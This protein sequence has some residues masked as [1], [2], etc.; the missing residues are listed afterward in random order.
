MRAKSG[1]TSITRRQVLKSGAAAFTATAAIGIAPR[2]LVPSVARAA[3]YASGMTGG[4]TGF[5]GAERYQYNESMS[6]GRAIEG[7]KQLKAAGKAPDKLVMMIL[8]GALAHLNKPWPADAPTVQSVWEKESGITLEFVTV[9]TGEEFSKIIRDVTTGEG[10][11]D[12]YTMP[13]N[14]IGDLAEAGGLVNCDDFVAKYQPDF[15]DAERGYVGG[16]RGVAQLNQ[17]D[18]VNYAV[19]LDG[20][21]QTWI[22][23]KDLFESDAERNKFSA[24]FGRELD[25]PKTFEELDQVSQ[26]FHRPDQG[27]NGCTDLRNQGW[28]YTNWY[29]RYASLGVPNQYL[30]S[31]DGEPLIDGEAGIQAAREY[32]DSLKWHST[33]AVSWSWP[34]QYGSM[35]DGGTAITC[36]FPNMPKFVDNDQT[37]VHNKMASALPPGRLHGDKLV[38]RSVLWYSAVGGVSSLSKYPEATWLFL[39]W[40][41][42]TRIFTWMTG[43]PGGYYDPFQLANFNDPLVESTYKA[44]HIPTLLGDAA[45]GVPSLNIA[46]ANAL[47]NALDENMVAAVTG[48]KTPE[49][50]MADTADEWRKTVRKK[51]DKLISAIRAYQKTWPDLI[52]EA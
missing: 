37:K 32:V 50:A 18:G 48:Q 22:Y 38:R 3:D 9:G 15:A 4:P 23:R 46:G 16:A 30:F 45:R 19:S 17:Y 1:K 21:Y 5:D 31:D 43:N 24:E 27:L 42:S 44:Y 41:G 14:A 36:A 25:Y 13:W 10:A 6:E 26:F 29:Q 40:L 11:Y 35:G 8:D 49:Q 51:G 28:G 34:E 52:D 12:V 7:I 2:Y 47:H 33:D 20:D 39:Q